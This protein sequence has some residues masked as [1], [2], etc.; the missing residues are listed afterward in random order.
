MRRR[1]RESVVSERQ[2]PLRALYAESPQHALALKSARTSTASVA[3]TDPFHG[4]VEVGRGYGTSLRFGLDRHIGGLEDAPNPGDLLCAA[5]AACQD[6]AIR[7]I[8]NLL[9]VELSEREVEVSGELDVR[10]CLAADPEVRVGFDALEC[11]V[12]LQAIEGTEPHRLDALIAAAE[13]FCVNLDTLR[14]G[15]EVTTRAR[16]DAPMPSRQGR[17]PRRTS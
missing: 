16:L 8:A 17:T 11:K 5:L 4:E 12:H 13:R 9:G 3:P 1:L 15:T 2:T 6:G 10:G 7:M 14:A